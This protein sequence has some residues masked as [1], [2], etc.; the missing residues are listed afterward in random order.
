MDAVTQETTNTTTMLGPAKDI[1]ETH[2]ISCLGAT[3]ANIDSYIENECGGDSYGFA[4]MVETMLASELE[5]KF[6]V[7]DTLVPGL[8]GYVTRVYDGNWMGLIEA[9]KNKSLY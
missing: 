1:C 9:Y 2:T 6:V 8:C 3:R 4:E 5:F 7:I